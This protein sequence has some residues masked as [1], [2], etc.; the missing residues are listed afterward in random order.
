MRILY[1]IIAILFTVSATAQTVT[2]GP[3]VGGVTINS[4]RAVVFCSAQTAVSIELSDDS[5]FANSRLFQGTTSAADGN[6]A[7]IDMDSLTSN[8]KYYYRAI[9]NGNPASDRRSFM[10]Y[11]CEGESLVFSFGMGS[12]M[13]ENRNDDEVFIE[14]KK[15]PLRFFMNVGDWGYPDDTDNYPSNSD[16]FAVDYNRVVQS[17]KDRYSY[18]YMSTF[19]KDVPI[20]YV[21]DDHDYVNDNAS[22]NTVPHTDFGLFNSTVI[23]DPMPPGTRRNAIKGYYNMFPGYAPVDSTQGIYHKFRFGNVEVFV[24]D[25]RASRSPNTEALTRP[26][27]FWEF[28][29]P[30][31]HSIIGDVQRQWLLD[32]LRSSTATWKFIVTS[33]AFNKSYRDAI[34]GL[35][36]LPSIAGLP[37]AAALID[38]WS[39]FPMD[40]DSIINAVNQGNIDGVIMMSG[41][42]HTSAIDDGQAGGL[43]EIMAG[44][45][46]QSNSTLFTTVPLQ[47]YGLTW[48]EGG[49]GIGG[50]TDISDAFANIQVNG[51]DH[52]TLELRSENGNVIASHTIYSCSYLT[53]LTLATD[54]IVNVGCHGD[55]TGAIHLSVTGGT[56]PYQYSL[57]GR[58]FQS[59]NIIGNLPIGTYKPAVK[60][61]GGCTKELCITITQPAAPLA[62]SDTSTDAT[63]FGLNNGTIDV[64]ASGGTFP[65]QYLWN[66]SDTVANRDSVL[67]GLYTVSVVDANL[68]EVVLQAEILQP[69]SLYAAIVTQDPTCYGDSN[70]TATATLVGGTPPYTISWSN[71]DT[72]ATQ[73]TFAAGTHSLTITDSYGCLFVDS[74][75]LTEPIPVSAIGNTTPDYGGN[76]GAVN[77]KANGGTEPYTYE[78]TDGSTDTT[79][80]GLTS[81]IYAVTVTDANGCTYDTTFEVTFISYVEDLSQLDLQ[82]FPNPAQNQVQVRY[83]LP[84]STA[85]TIKLYNLLGAE[86]YSQTLEAAISGSHTLDLSNIASGSY[87]ILIQSSKFQ[88]Q[89][90]LVVE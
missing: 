15:Y 69:D 8:T 40:Q 51:D 23:E 57:D 5:T 83:T 38:C 32:N 4:A 33:T 28:D 6:V 34:D 46:S 13:N 87:I 24:L 17:Y 35:L 26:G 75:T 66:D 41:D 11:P 9:I 20:D 61:A 84:F 47:A 65:Y 77:V 64:T 56:P 62:A 89:K 14:A 90:K 29:P 86:L 30:P 18:R 55:S 52:V 1:A 54:S 70:G 31:G 74:V 58:N 81:G 82:V 67:A 85:I 78:W 22:A 50:N 43:P 71:G 10:T 16:Y 3:I 7:L 2:Q 44:A 42:T 63:C 21:W 27:F 80:S 68:C 73:S 45:L 19:L 49:Q 39:G 59:S 12:C 53:G 72:L 79:L 88:A 48:S 36:N 76:E 60:D 25:D 37:L